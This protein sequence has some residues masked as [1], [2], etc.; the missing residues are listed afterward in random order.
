VNE[1]K[2]FD[3]PIKKKDLNEKKIL[4]KMVTKV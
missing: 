4:F 1:N 3:R 2:R